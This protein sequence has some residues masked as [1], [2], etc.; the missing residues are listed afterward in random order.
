MTDN[1][2][3]ID[4]VAAMEET[5]RALRH[6]ERGLRVSCAS[7]H[8]IGP[9]WSQPIPFLWIDAS[10]DYEDIRFDITNFTP[11]VIADGLTALDDSV[12]G[13]FPGDVQA[14]AEWELRDPTYKRTATLRNISVFRGVASF[15]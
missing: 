15:G 10:R 11:H 14:I 3:D 13:D 9:A 8:E 5:V 12:A 4:D 1:A 6:A 2:I 7:S